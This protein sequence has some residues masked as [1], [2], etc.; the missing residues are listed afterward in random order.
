M[1]FARARV[2][3]ARRDE[4]PIDVAAEAVF[5]PGVGDGRLEHLAMSRH[6]L[7]IS[8]V[9]SAWNHGPAAN[10]VEHQPAFCADDR[11]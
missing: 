1:R 4:E 8:S 10:Q 6:A 11:M 2:G 3:V 9:A 7:R 5:L